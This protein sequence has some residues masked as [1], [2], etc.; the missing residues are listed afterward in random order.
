[1]RNNQWIAFPFIGTQGADT[2]AIGGTYVGNGN[3]TPTIIDLPG[4]PSF[5]WIRGVTSYITPISWFS[6]GLGGHVGGDNAVNQCI[7]R[8]W[9]DANGYHVSITGNAY[10][11][12]NGKTFQ[13]IIFCYP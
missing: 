3:S 10:Y 9:Y 1:M 2:Y 8:V 7:S 5:I 4:P 13:Y 6:A 11:D 12:N